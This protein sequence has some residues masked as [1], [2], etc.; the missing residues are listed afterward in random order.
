MHFFS[1]THSCWK[2]KAVGVG[3]DDSANE[4][5]R[6]MDNGTIVS[7]DGCD[8]TEQK[9]INKKH[10]EFG[11]CPLCSEYQMVKVSWVK[12]SKH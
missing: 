7:L 2:P 12:E 10:G 8:Q 9:N 1:R 4:T 5:E 11:K 3:N 6:R